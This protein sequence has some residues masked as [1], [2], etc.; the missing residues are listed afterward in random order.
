M[1]IALFSSKF[2]DFKGLINKSELVPSLLNIQATTRVMPII[3]KVIVIKF[4]LRFST[5]VIGTGFI[6]EKRV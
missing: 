2:L 3:G 1:R 6:G 4:Y 5:I